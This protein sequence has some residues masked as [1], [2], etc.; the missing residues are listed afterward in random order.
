MK[1]S[2]L[3]TAII[4]LIS[5]VFQSCAVELS[6]TSSW[7]DLEGGENARQITVNNNPNVILR[8]GELFG[9]TDS[10]KKLLV[11]EYQITH[12]IDLRDEVEVEYY[13]DPIIDG[14]EYHH[15]NVW[16]REV[17][18]RNIEESTIDGVTD[19]DLFIEKY[20]TVFAF[21]PNAIEA[22]QNMFAILLETE[23]GSVL[24]HCTH[25]KDRTG[26]AITLILYALGFDW[27]EIEREYLLSN[28]VYAGS[29]DISWLRYYRNIIIQKYGSMEKYLETEIGLDDNNLR[30]LRKKYSSP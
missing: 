4:V 26:I 7:I 11:D 21:D 1:K 6:F 22:Y 5:I 28:A 9:L 14:V 12:I 20:Y 30:I 17:R 10:D 24:I 19:S 18:L 15:F 16:R 27:D 8:T 25:G 29:V 3:F 13:P 23:T 2:V